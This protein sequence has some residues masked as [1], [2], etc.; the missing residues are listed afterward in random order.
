MT[1]IEKRRAGNKRCCRR[2]EGAL[3]G[4][5]KNESPERPLWKVSDGH[6]SKGFVLIVQSQYGI[7]A[8][9]YES[10]FHPQR[11]FPFKRWWIRIWNQEDVSNHCSHWDLQEHLSRGH[12]RL[13]VLSIRHFS[14]ELKGQGLLSLST[15][16]LLKLAIYRNHSGNGCSLS[17]A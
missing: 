5:G 15:R 1:T 9:F 4:A 2:E 14:F 16:R 7:N 17:H 6:A 11:C 10:K 3:S 13:S 12:A 8:E